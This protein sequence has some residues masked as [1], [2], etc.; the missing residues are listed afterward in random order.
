MKN[1]L[2]SQSSRIFRGNLNVK[3]TSQHRR[4]AY[5]VVS[6]GYLHTRTTN[7]YGLGDVGAEESAAGKRDHVTAHCSGMSLLQS[8]GSIER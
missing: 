2:Q 6:L 3:I 1:P 8:S 7:G 5:N 4:L